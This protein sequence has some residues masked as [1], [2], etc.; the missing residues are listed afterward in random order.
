MP[1]YEFL[2]LYV[3]IQKNIALRGHMYQAGEHGLQPS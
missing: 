2:R 3:L 1:E